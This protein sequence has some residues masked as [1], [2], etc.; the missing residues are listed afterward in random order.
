MAVKRREG[1]A[2]R[3]ETFTTHYTV[4]EPPP[5]PLS[6][7]DV[8]RLVDEHGAACERAVN[9]DLLHVGHRDQHVVLELLKHL[10]DTK[11]RSSHWMRSELEKFTL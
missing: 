5:P 1:G 4:L 3:E 9:F 2:E 8:G 10:Q 6:R 11:T 7:S